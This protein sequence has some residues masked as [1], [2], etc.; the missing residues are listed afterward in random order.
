MRELRATA[1]E[2]P[3]AGVRRHLLVV[4]A[5]AGEGRSIMTLAVHDPD[6]RVRATALQYLARLAPPEDADAH[7]LLER[8]LSDGPPDLRVGCIAGLRADA[9]AAVH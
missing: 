4:L 7:D 2:E 9:P 5:G 3:D 6:E 1:A 8:V